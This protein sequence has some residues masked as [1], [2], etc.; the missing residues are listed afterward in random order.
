MRRNF[1][2]RYHIF[3]NQILHVILTIKNEI[4]SA[5]FVFD[6][7]MFSLLKQTV[8]SSSNQADFKL[9]LFKKNVSRDCQY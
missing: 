5:S 9:Q 6:T 7:K 4:I 3:L 2:L 1:K 8:N